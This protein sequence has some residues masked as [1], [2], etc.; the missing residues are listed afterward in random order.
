MVRAGRDLHVR[1]WFDRV[2][3][4]RDLHVPSESNIIYKDKINVSLQ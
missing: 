4:S 3:V 2:R 1:I